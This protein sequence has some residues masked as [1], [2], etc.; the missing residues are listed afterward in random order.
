MSKVFVTDKY[1]K[2]SLTNLNRKIE[3]RVEQ[4]KEAIRVGKNFLEEYPIIVNEDFVVLDGQHRFYAAKEMG[5]LLYYI[6]SQKYTIDDI[7]RT[8][9]MQ[10]AWT[11]T[12]YLDTNVNRGVEDYQILQAFMEKYGLGIEVSRS[13][14]VGAKMGLPQRNAFKNGEFK[15]KDYNKA[16]K[17]AEHIHQFREY[18]DG[19]KERIFVFA[20]INLFNHPEYNPDE[21]IMKV[22]YQ[23]NKLRK[24]TDV[25]SY[26]RMLE[27][28]YNY[29]RRETVR[30][31]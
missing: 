23:N 13:I 14:L 18:F 11:A 3:G 12:D 1:D 6:I 9:A 4:F 29:K 31:V 28:I 17:I 24:C 27:E 5:V 10:K 30:F 22:S 15:I 7:A 8:N 16:V 25:K 2:F 20:I 19:W 26:M 21:M